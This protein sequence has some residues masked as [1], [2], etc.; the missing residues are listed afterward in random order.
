M[1]VTENAKEAG[2]KLPVVITEAL[3][4][5][6]APTRVDQGLGQD[7]EGRLWDELWLAS[8]TI[9]LAD[10]GM[11]TVSFTVVLQEADTKS[12]RLQNIDLR[13]WAVRGPG[14]EGETVITVCFPE[15]F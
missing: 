6:L 10:P 5:R 7:Y 2:F 1:D 15:D 4:N 8:F 3:E 9:K 11:D 12:G 13:L 14:Y